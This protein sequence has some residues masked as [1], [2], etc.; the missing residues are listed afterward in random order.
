MPGPGT[1]SRAQA[2]RGRFHAAYTAPDLPVPVEAIAEDPLGL[3]VE[4]TEDLKAKEAHE[5]LVYCRAAD[6]APTAD[7]ALEREPW[8]F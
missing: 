8:S 4:E 3:Y 7:R 2:L 5:A 1:D 6:V